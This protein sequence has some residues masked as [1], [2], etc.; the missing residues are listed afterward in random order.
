[1]P[2]KGWRKFW[3]PMKPEPLAPAMEADI[4]RIMNEARKY[5]KIQ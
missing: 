3:P 1:M 2:G 5:Y 4:E